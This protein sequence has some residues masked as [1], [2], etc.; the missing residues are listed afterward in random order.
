MTI[1]RF[2]FR[3]GFES[4]DTANQTSHLI[5]SDKEGR[6]SFD[7]PYVASCR[8]PEWLC[9]S[10]IWICNV[11]GNVPILLHYEVWQPN[12]GGDER[13]NRCQLTKI[14]EVQNCIR[15]ATGSASA[16]LS[17][18]G[19]L[20]FDGL[21][22]NTDYVSLLELLVFWTRVEAELVNWH[23]DRIGLFNSVP[24]NNIH[25]FAAPI[26]ENIHKLRDHL[27]EVIDPCKPDEPD[28]KA[29]RAKRTR[30]VLFAIAQFFRTNADEFQLKLHGSTQLQTPISKS[31]VPNETTLLS[32]DREN[33]YWVALR[34]SQLGLGAHT[35]VNLL[36]L[37]Y[38]TEMAEP[39]LVQLLGKGDASYD[40][41]HHKVE[42]GTSTSKKDLQAW[43]GVEIIRTQRCSYPLLAQILNDLFDDDSEL[44]AVRKRVQGFASRK[45]VS[46]PRLTEHNAK[47]KTKS[48][49]RSLSEEP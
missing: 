11:W 37:I 23:R 21:A 39:D 22:K 20:I 10:E 19:K 48:D 12:T 5:Y 7:G 34:A 49:Y 30:E 46:L 13:P 36:N 18:A 6:E 9:I 31:A 28:S 26:G 33:Q 38:D 40:N 25:G 47:L 2:R 1:V 44:G 16:S 43:F 35:I 3:E 32:G 14:A 41:Q 4:V 29:R 45:S 42:M 8:D 17:A 24:C 27:Q 15:Q